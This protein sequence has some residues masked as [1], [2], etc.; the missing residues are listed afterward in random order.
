MFFSDYAYMAQKIHECNTRSPS[1]T[2][3]KSVFRTIQERAALGEECLNDEC[4]DEEQMKDR[5]GRREEEE[6]MTQSPDTLI[7]SINLHMELATKKR[8]VC[9]AIS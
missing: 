1:N 3:Q 6:R 9:A 7:G 2:V 5:I 8:E 4:E